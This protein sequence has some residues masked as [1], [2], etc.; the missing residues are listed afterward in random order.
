MASFTDHLFQ[1]VLIPVTRN[2]LASTMVLRHRWD[3]WLVSSPL[4]FPLLPKNGMKLQHKPQV[5]RK[6]PTSLRSIKSQMVRPD[7]FQT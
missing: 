4:P 2:I 3:S 7:L 5:L 1:R 6:L